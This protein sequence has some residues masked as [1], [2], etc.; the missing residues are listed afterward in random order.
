[1]VRKSRKVKKVKN[2]KNVKNVSRRKSRKVSRKKVSRKFGY[3][4]GYSQKV[5]NASMHDGILLSKDAY[6]WGNS[7][8]ARSLMSG[9]G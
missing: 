8:L 5:Y 9:S 6:T 1:M 2:V 4:H 7:P 3:S